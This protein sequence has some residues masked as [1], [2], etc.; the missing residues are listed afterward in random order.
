MYVMKL[1]IRP[2][3]ANLFPLAGILVRGEDV[4]TW[5]K[6]IMYLKLSL[7]QVTVY[8]V[9]GTVAGNLWGC[10]I[11]TGDVKIEDIGRNNYCQLV[12][13]TLFIPE[14]ATIY[15]LL[16]SAELVHVCASRKHLYHP[17]V[18]WCELEEPVAWEQ[19]INTNEPGIINVATP[20]SPVF[21]PQAI[22][23]FQVI[24]VPPEESL[25]ELERKVVPQQKKFTD[26]PLSLIEKGK[27]MFYR[28]LWHK[29]TGEDGY[30]KTGILSQIGSV[31][32]QDSINRMQ[33]DMENLEQRN[34]NE[35]D[36]LL[37]LLQKDP[38]EALKYAIPLDDTGSTRGGEKGR[39]TLSKR[40]PDF[41]IF[42]SSQQSHGSGTVTLGDGYHQLY[43]QYRQT[44]QQLVDNKDYLKAS[45][46]Y[47]KLLKDYHTAALV[48][49]N[50]K[51]FQEAASVHL[52]HLNNKPKAA[53]CYE[54]GNMYHEAIRIYEEL[55]GYDEKIG[56]LY[57]KTGNKPEAMRYYGLVADS[58]T[59]S[60]QY[61][62]ASL[63]YRNKMQ[64]P[65]RGQ[66]LLLEGWQANRDA[67]NCL[68]NYLTN[69]G[70]AKQVGDTLRSLYDGL[71][72]VHREPFL[73]ALKYEYDK[74]KELH[75]P[76]R[77]MAYE[78]VSAQLPVN[79]EIISELITFNK[80]DSQ[81]VK[82][83]MRYRLNRKK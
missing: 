27:L 76:I 12:A 80:K 37:N 55:N 82:D 7:G 25:E 32:P 19:L 21:I 46:V 54:K 40:W 52:K 64:E 68:N 6:E 53:D 48:L 58:Y 73:K 67:F 81:L 74:Y 10:L 72:Q 5:L 66:D 9:P 42:G 34:Q 43:T 49:E 65:Q 18:G 44:A 4:R 22:K 26:K 36:K 41:S 16:S 1:E 50:G 23:S 33:Q 30:E 51:L 75:T 69:M 45:F 61:V 39:F 20:V 24:P 77:D 62:K 31:L 57:L 47:I 35:V 56:D 17:E 71:D 2:H 60:G 13:G 59:S 29:K 11:V 70:N 38:E 28:K 3:S 14:R 63:V 83:T 79:Q 15:P 8:P 78:M